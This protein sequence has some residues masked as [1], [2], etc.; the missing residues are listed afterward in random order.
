MRIFRR[1]LIFLVSITS[2]SQRNKLR[3]IS[4]E[5]FDKLTQVAETHFSKT[6]KP[7]H[8]RR[9]DQRAEQSGIASH[10][11]TTGNL[12]LHI[13]SPL[14]PTISG[15]STFTLNLAYSLS[16]HFQVGL[17]RS[18]FHAGDIVPQDGFRSYL[19]K[20]DENESE[21]LYMLGNGPHHLA[22]WQ[23]LLIE[24]GF[25]FVHDARIPN[26]PVQES[27]DE[28]WVNLQFEEKVS[29][30]LGRIPLHTKGIITMS[31]ETAR[32]VKEQLTEYQREKIPI[33]VLSTGHP[34]KSA[35]IEKTLNSKKTIATFGFVDNQK[36]PEQTI[37]LISDI[38]AKTK[39]P[40]LICGD[41]S[42]QNKSMFK[43]TWR[44]TGNRRQDL[45]FKSGLS[46]EEFE[47]EIAGAKV[48]IQLRR[49]S[50]GETSGVIPM[51]ASYGVPTVVSGLGSFNELPDE[52]FYKLSPTEEGKLSDNYQVIF[53]KITDLIASDETYVAQERK[54]IAW[55]SN[56]TFD[57]AAM[58][59]A[60]FILSKS[61]YA[62][63]ENQ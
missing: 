47:E 34:A 33:L 22:T 5:I 17:R 50:N 7:Q 38:S 20:D 39:L 40:A 21:R 43:R 37:K 19:F 13:F 41:I 3:K 55:S 56:K 44:K 25:V 46:D 1:L 52:L 63:P 58:E 53:E 16:N 42:A 8:A 35:K 59:V 2:P 31:V 14:P 60:D 6:N 28:K 51:L 12:R 18:Y 61:S 49:F 54:M 36:D 10:L 45:V 26:I 9:F 24:P 48:A 29:R 62:S 32:Q 4:P 15:I 23:K 27:E 57:V 11:G 30:Y